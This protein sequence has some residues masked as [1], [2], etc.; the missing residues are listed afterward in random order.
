MGLPEVLLGMAELG[1][2]MYMLKV[3]M[4]MT[5]LDFI[6]ILFTKNY[7]HVLGTSQSFHIQLKMCY[8]PIDFF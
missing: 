6:H 7:D 8:N 4:V 3:S 2:G 1:A 5:R